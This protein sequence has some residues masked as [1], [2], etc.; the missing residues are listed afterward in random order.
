MHV[1]GI[2]QA[3]VMAR[4]IST[5]PQRCRA[6][7]AVLS[8]RSLADNRSQSLASLIWISALKLSQLLPRNFQFNILSFPSSRRV[9]C[10]SDRSF[11]RMAA[12][13]APRC[14]IRFMLENHWQSGTGFE[15]KG[16]IFLPSEQ[17][18]RKLVLFQVIAS[19]WCYCF[20]KDSGRTGNSRTQTCASI[21]N[22]RHQ[23]NF[24]AQLKKIE[25]VPNGNANKDINRWGSR[26]LRRR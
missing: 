7:M 14:S 16:I 6:P 8:S 10:V 15:K 25:S 2:F 9:R 1:W 26:V 5:T 23:N 17:M 13:L 4:I 24:S 12:K 22:F 11:W 21:D 18:G 19:V 20:C 3:L